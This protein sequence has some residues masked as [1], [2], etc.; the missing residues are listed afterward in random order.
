[1]FNTTTFIN[2]DS[3]IGTLFIRGVSHYDNGSVIT[4]SDGNSTDVITTVT[5][6]VYEPLDRPKN[7]IIDNVTSSSFTARW[8]A[9]SS[10]NKPPVTS[11][12]ITW[13][14]VDRQFQGLLTEHG[15]TDS[16]VT[17]FTTPF[18]FVSVHAENDCGDGEATNILYND[19]V[20]VIS[21]ER[22]TVGL[23]GDTIT[24]SCWSSHN[25]NTLEWYQQGDTSDISYF[26]S[27]QLV[28]FNATMDHIRSV[29]YCT[30]VDHPIYYNVFSELILLT[31]LVSFFHDQLELPTPVIL[32]G[33]TNTVYKLLCGV[34]TQG[35]ELLQYDHQFSGDF[36]LGIPH[37]YGAVVLFD[38]IVGSSYFASIS[39]TSSGS[40]ESALLL[41]T[42]SSTHVYVQN[43]SAFVGTGNS[44]TLTYYVAVNS[45]GHSNNLGAI[46]HIWVQFTSSSTILTRNITLFDVSDQ[47]N[48]IANDNG[49]NLIISQASLQVDGDYTLF[50]VA[51]DGTMSNATI[52]VTVAQVE[53]PVLVFGP[54]DQHVNLTQTTTFTC[55]ATGYNVTYKWTI[56]SGSFPSKV[57]GIN[58]NS[59]VIPDVRSS[60]DNTYTCV[61]SN[62]G[63]NVSSNTARLT[64]TGLPE[65]TVTPSSQSVEVTRTAMFTTTVSG[66]GVENFM[67]QWRHNRTIINE[68]NNITLIII[69]VMSSDTGDYECIVTN[70][71]GNNIVSS[72]ST[73]VITVTPPV[74]TT[75][76]MD[77]T[78]TLAADNFNYSL[79]CNADGATSFNWGRQSGSIPSGATRVNTNT[80]TI[81]NVTPEDAGNYRCVATNASGS[82]V[83]NYS[84][85]IINVQLPDFVTHPSPQSVDLTQT[86]T[87]TCSATGYNV[88]YKWTIGSGSF[89]S[90]VTGINTNTLVI[91]DVR[92]SDDN[93]Y[94]C[95][96]SNEGGN[97]SSNTARLTVTGLPE[98]TVTPSSQSV[99]VTHTAIFTTTVSG[100]G[101][102]NFLYQW[103][104]NEIEILEETQANLSIINITENS[105][106]NYDCTV[107]NSHGDHATSEIATLIVLRNVPIITI[108]P[109]NITLELD[110]ST[111]SVSLTCGADGATSYNWERQD[112]S[113]LSDASGVNTNTLTINNPLPVDTGNYRCVATNDSGSSYSNYATVNIFSINID[114]CMM[115]T[116][117][118]YGITWPSTQAGEVAVVYC[119]ETATATR[120]C[121]INSIWQSFDVTGCETDQYTDLLTTTEQLLLS[122]TQISTTTFSIDATTEVVTSLATLTQPTKN[123]SILPMNLQNTN[124]VIANMLMIT[125]IVPTVLDSNTFVED[126]ANVLSNVL[127]A[128]NIMGWYEL[129]NMK[130][131]SGQQFLNNAE[132]FTLQL[133]NHTMFMEMEERDIVQDNIVLSTRVQTNRFSDVRFPA[134]DIVTNT[135]FV[136]AF[137]VPLAPIVIP[138]SVI[139][140][141]SV[142][143][144]NGSVAVGNAIIQT[145]SQVLSTRITG[146][147]GRDIDAVSFGMI[148]S[149]QIIGN[150]SFNQDPIELNFQITRNDTQS[151]NLFCGFFEE[152]DGGGWSTEGVTVEE[153]SNTHIKCL[154]THLTSFAVLVDTAGV[155]QDISETELKV[156]SLATYV[157]CSISVI[158]LL[159]TIF[160]LL[161]F[162]KTLLK[163]MHNFVHLNLSV[164]LLLG[165]TTFLAGIE[166][167]TENDIA[168]T[169][170]AVLLHYF[171]TAVFTWMMCEGIM[172]YLLLVKVFS[173]F[174]TKKR[175]IFLL[176]GWGVPVP[177]VAIAVGIAHEQYGTDDYCWLSTENESIWGFVVPVLAIIIVNIIFLVL[178]VRAATKG[179]RSKA[180]ATG[181]EINKL[182]TAKG[183]V[184][185]TLFLLPLFGVSWI[186]GLLA[187]H[188]NLSAFTWL[189]V[190][191]NSLQGAC[192]FFLYVIRQEKVKQQLCKICCR[193]RITL[194]SSTRQTM[195]YLSKPHSREYYEDGVVTANHYVARTDF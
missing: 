35:G 173:S 142:S 38:V 37:V 149:S 16:F 186:F 156:L 41:L 63:G 176:L 126:T 30:F 53:P 96:A 27:Q 193:K 185:D 165:Y 99:E 138:A 89:P 61:A 81:T 152:S 174:I 101:V 170:V 127:D 12:T 157:G 105:S 39:C 109:T 129:Q 36:L 55:S 71:Y 134:S 10:T 124:D 28:S 137:G 91:P 184:R 11:Y 88:T 175:W 40:G 192:I 144:Q 182:Q 158:C 3:L 18:V 155:Q 9:V 94:T 42:S 34:G 191:F 1:M 154:S 160:I 120:L 8:D 179:R 146:N 150:A 93:T 87:F 50:V 122:F 111:S 60:D 69:G 162:W 183:L 135:S 145:L 172:I 51:D 143:S 82:S 187:F 104:R 45:T 15:M 2:N 98:V 141:T 95:V 43:A 26:S 100:V 75:H 190:I 188:R 80:L 48:L 125:T 119:T 86:A 21:P 85:L 180:L 168:C 169:I 161:L 70:E 67:Y 84:T 56:G 64:V 76:P 24:L 29:F 19:T 178:G 6:L 54:V 4:C 164:A 107:T 116:D 72:V 65:V 92:S 20:I 62:E 128:N 59:L 177:I 49:Y 13:Y 131:T 113:I 74:I 32:T 33:A 148:L 79:I 189:F 78:V 115:E 166:T 23:V 167:A 121:N 106:G 139:A 159:F 52:T 181:K 66:V 114:G 133:A 102:E 14:G 68:E 153:S 44:I 136:D 163:D 77:D 46:S 194:P 47:Y 147:K 7:L 108:H 171:F 58:T 117:N 195:F 25:N 140:S 123:V 73:L 57:T 97:V 22:Y 110:G 130:N 132:K 83:S 31:K 17:G 118:D 151:L 103:R 5:I 112:G 90:K